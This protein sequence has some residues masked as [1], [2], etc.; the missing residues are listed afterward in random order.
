MKR[1]TTKQGRTYSTPAGELTSVTTFLKACAKPAL[2]NWA[3]AEERKYIL[4]VLEGG[5]NG[6]ADLLAR[7]GKEKAHSKL[8]SAAGDIG[9]LLHAHAEAAFR[10][11]LGLP[12][13]EVPT[14]LG[15][16]AAIAFESFQAWRKDSGFKVTDVEQMVWSSDHEFAGTLDFKGILDGKEVIG[17][18]KTSKRFYFEHPLQLSAYR[19]AWLER[20]NRASHPERSGVGGLIVKLPKTAD[21]TLGVRYFSPEELDTYFETFMAV[22]T[23]Y[24]AME[25]FEA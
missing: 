16:E 2:V 12:I 19:Q 4:K 7:L 14:P 21:G 23:L 24:N 17:D 1:T 3:A 25:A 18:L 8:L 22:Q 11:E 9:T 5:W 10:E 6:E 20:N 13:K 15:P